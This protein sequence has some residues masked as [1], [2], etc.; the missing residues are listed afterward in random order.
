MSKLRANYRHYSLMYHPD[1]LSEFEDV[2]GLRNRFLELQ[3]AYN[4]LKD[5]TLRQ[6]YSRFGEDALKCTSCKSERDYFDM[7]FWQSYLVFYLPA[8][9]VML[10]TVII[11]PSK[12]TP[13]FWNVALFFSLASI[14]AFALLHGV[15]G[16][17]YVLPKYTLH[18]KVLLLRQF[19]LS[20][21]ITLNQLGA[22]V[23]DLYF[24]DDDNE[25]LLNRLQLLGKSLLQLSQQTLKEHINLLGGTNPE[26]M[27]SLALQVSEAVC[28]IAVSKEKQIQTLISQSALAG[29]SP[30]KPS[31]TSRESSPTR[32]NKNSTP[33]LK[34][35]Q[36]PIKPQ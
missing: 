35:R 23:T 7:V 14:E 20:G 27:E 32:T 9:I 24:E 18:E 15:P 29:T 4:V 28:R 21:Q 11:L 1:K 19:F 6:A 16:L 3:K 13:R 25:A 10:I 12:R 22:I 5:A 34:K 2:E 8:C 36:P 33:N 30:S 26:S 31:D 17:R